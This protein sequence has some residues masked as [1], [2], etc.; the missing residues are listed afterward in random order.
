MMNNIK[1]QL[2]LL[3]ERPNIIWAFLNWT[4]Q[5]MMII[6]SSSLVKSPT[7]CKMV[8]AVMFAGGIA[9]MMKMEGVLKIMRLREG[10]G[11]MAGD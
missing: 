9:A 7:E 6:W 5:R 3:L 8:G 4:E 2:T 10:I 1:K 11:R